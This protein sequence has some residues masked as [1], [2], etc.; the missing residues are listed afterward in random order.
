LYEAREGGQNAGM[1]VVKQ[2]YGAEMVL[3]NAVIGTALC[4]YHKVE[5]VIFWA[6]SRAMS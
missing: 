6:F 3:L 5:F 1:G 4:M 2:T